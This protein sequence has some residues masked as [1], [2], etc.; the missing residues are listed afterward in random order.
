MPSC[1]AENKSHGERRWLILQLVERLIKWC[2]VLALVHCSLNRGMTDYRWCARSFLLH[3]YTIHMSDSC[4]GGCILR[5]CLLGNNSSSTAK[6]I[7]IHTDFLEKRCSCVFQAPKITFLWSFSDFSGDSSACLQVDFFSGLI[8]RTFCLQWSW[9]SA[10]VALWM[11]TQVET[12][13]HFKHHPLLLP[14]CV[15]TFCD[16]PCASC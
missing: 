5:L 13:A 9:W 10:M 16:R 3:P 14:V 2:V 11:D 15:Q 8:M 12:A 7:H 1:T 6:V 4:T